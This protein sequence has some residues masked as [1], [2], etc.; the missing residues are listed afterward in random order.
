MPERISSSRKRALERLR[1]VFIAALVLPVA[2]FVAL[3][4]YLYRQE[5]ADAQLRLRSEVRIAE[6][7][8]LKLFESNEMLLQRLLDLTKNQTDDQL[9]SRS[10]ELHQELKRMASGLPQV[11]TLSIQGVDS[12]A[13][14]NSR[15]DP[16]PRHL[17]YSDRDWYR[18]ARSGLGPPVFV[19]EQNVSRS[20]GELFFSMSRTRTAR[21]ASFAGTVHVSLRPEYFSNFYAEL[22]KSE[23]GLY[24]FIAR[25]DGSLLAR[26]PDDKTLPRHLPA[27]DPLL[28]AFAHWPQ[29]ASPATSSPQEAPL[30]EYRKLG[31]YPVFAVASIDASAVV[32]AWWASMA[33]LALLVFPTALGFA[34]MA[35]V[36]LR[37]TSQE[38]EVATRL[39]GEEERRRQA[40]IAL[41]QGQK[42]EALGRLT[43][44]VAHDFNNILMVM[45]NNLSFHQRK[46]AAF[47]QDPEL[48]AIGRAV[49][50]GTKL[51]RQLLAFSRTQPM[52]PRNI[53][54]T[55]RL[56]AMLELVRPI[57]GSSVELRCSIAT[58]IAAI[59]V[60]PDELELGLINLAVNAKHAMLRGG[61]IDVIVR[62]AVD[63]ECPKSRGDFVLFEV[64]D[65]GS[66]I[67][68]E[69]TA[70]VFEPFFTTKPVGSGTGLGLSQ[71]QAMCESAGGCATVAPRVGGGTRVLLFFKAYKHSTSAEIAAPAALEIEVH[72]RLLLVEDTDAVAQAIAKVF[73]SQGCDVQRVADGDAAVEYLKQRS[74]GV[75]VVLSDI[76]MPGTLDG[77]GLARWVQAQLPHIPVVLMSGNPDNLQE[78]ARLQ[79]EVL[80]KPCS[81][82][83]LTGAVFEARRAAELA[84]PSPGDAG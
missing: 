72:C 43:S 55:N 82:A 39:E 16:P 19:S 6:E 56:P 5:F 83:V 41:V 54:L 46:N 10:A 50:S 32:A 40:E 7:Q 4:T 47:A 62:N 70:R 84:A 53:D 25:V 26:W 1:W 73:E 51:T 59:E 36:A 9:L 2:G 49:D 67:P 38:F 35:G 57:M 69:N 66:G 74:A 37:R 8:A 22:A 64:A 17:D 14:A 78:A 11:Q 30:I 71:V 3:G 13:V 45:M 60:D 58:D 18:M 63:G 80:R 42:L 15:I 61:R 81:P 68:P 21:D 27:G 34:W 79:L 29:Q 52:R 44:G 48:T 75:D 23:P 33:P 31:A 20:T 12:R 77:F 76:Q 65:N 24:I 28:S